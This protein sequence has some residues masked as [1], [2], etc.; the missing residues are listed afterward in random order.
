MRL[1]KVDTVELRKYK[2]KASDRRYLGIVIGMEQ[3]CIK[4]R[5]LE[6]VRI[7]TEAKLYTLQSHSTTSKPCQNPEEYKYSLA[8]FYKNGV[9]R[10]NLL[11][12]GQRKETM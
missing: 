8:K 12:R 11:S 1:A 10:F 3:K 6:P 4:Y 7:F 9:D 5:F 2:V